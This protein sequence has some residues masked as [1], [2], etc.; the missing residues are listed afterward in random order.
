MK[1]SLDNFLDLPA[2]L[3]DL[4]HSHYV[5]LPIPYEH[6]RDYRTGTTGGPMAILEASRKIARFDPELKGEFCSRGI[7]T[8]PI[9][10]P[11]AGP[12]EQ[13]NRIK[14]TA[15]PVMK[16]GKFLLSLGGEHSLTVPLV[17]CAAEAHGPIS[18]LQID[19]HAELSDNF[20]DIELSH[21]CTM[22]RIMETAE[23]ICQVGI[24][25]FSKA[26]FDQCPQQ[27]AN[28]IT[29]E[30][31][32]SDKGW[33]K[34]AI[35]LLGPTVY[36]T[37]DISGLDPSIAP[38]TG[39]PAPDGLTWKQIT[40]LLRAVCSDRKVVAADI[41][42]VHPLGENHITEALAARLAYKIIAYTQLGA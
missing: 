4:A 16:A 20:D 6:R 40:S 38:G 42:E 19:A 35:S 12:Y 17:Q 8:Y 15:L 2:E 9:I 32:A 18:V 26:Q 14:A 29:P 31:I 10:Q 21:S 1:E 24:R 33:I 7:T 27:V 23:K 3:R 22:R 34:K 28:F 41:M 25:S 36:V 39:M 37:I 30:V 5:I 11:A 13:T